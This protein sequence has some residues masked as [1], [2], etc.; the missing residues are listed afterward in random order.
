MSPAQG[1]APAHVST[2]SPPP[3]RFNVL[4]PTHTTHP[5]TSTAGPERTTQDREERGSRSQTVHQGTRSLKH[6][7]I[8]SPNVAMQLGLSC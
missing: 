5:L 8:V 2:S 7:P 1:P 6:D 3:I 4:P